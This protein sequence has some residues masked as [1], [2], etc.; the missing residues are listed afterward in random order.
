M[1]A[2]RHAQIKE[3]FIRICELPEQY[4]SAALDRVC[5]DDL[6][7]RREVE[8]LLSFHG[9]SA[10][11]SANTM[12][13]DPLT[14]H[15]KKDPER[16][17]PYR[18]LRKLGEG[19]MGVVYE[20]RQDQPVRRKLALKL[21]KWGMDTEEVLARFESERQALAIMNHPNVA[22]VFEAGSTEKG[23]PYFTMEYVEGESLTAYCD[24]H[25]LN[26]H[27]RLE[28]FMQVCDGV[29]HAH[30]NGII[31][32]DIK[33]SNVLVR[34][35]EDKPVPTIIDFGVAKATQQRLTERTLYT[36]RGMLIGTPEYMSPEQA[37]LSGPDVDTRTDVYSLGVVLY[38]ILVGALPFDSKTLR[39]AGFDEIRRKIREEEPSKPSTRVSTLGDASSETARR[40]RT[41]PANLRRELSGDMDWIT[42]K[43]LEKDRTRRYTS[44]AE[45]TA[46]IARHLRHEPVLASPSST[47]ERVSK[48]VRRHWIGVAAWSSVMLALAIGLAL[49]TSG[50][51]RAKRAE[52][53]ARQEAATATKVSEL[54]M[55]LFD[56]L[57][58]GVPGHVVTLEQILERGTQR[59]ETELA[60]E[61]V[62]Q[63]RLL[64]YLA[65]AQG[66]V[67]NPGRG[68][69]LVERSVQLL[70]ENLP[71][72]HPHLGASV[73]LLGDVVAA[74]GD[75]DQAQRLHEEALG[76]WK[77]SLGPD[78]TSVSLGRAYKSL[79]L[80]QFQ[81]GNL[82][83]SRSYMDKAEWVL[84]RFTGTYRIH[85]AYTLYWQGLLDS[86]YEG[87]HK[88]ALAR[89]EQALEI[90]ETEFGPEHN[91][92]GNPLFLLGQIHYRLGNIETARSYYDRVLSIRER[93]FGEDSHAVAKV[94]T[95]LGELLVATG[96]ME[97]ARQQLERAFGILEGNA[98][99]AN[100]DTAWCVRCL[101]TVYRQSGEVDRARQLLQ[102]SLEALE[103]SMGSDHPGLTRTLHHL[104]QLELQAGNLEPAR[105]WYRQTLEIQSKTWE[106]GHYVN[107]WALY[108]LACIAVREGKNEQA[109]SLLRQAL[110]NGYDRETILEDT[111]LANLRGDL[112]F[113]KIVNEVE[114]RLLRKQ[115]TH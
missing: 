25:C 112:E 92:A 16:I 103:S 18:V 9:K 46:D 48:F 86:E 87:D 107:T 111:D 45:L 43:A 62:L 54:L 100:A 14:L 74:T 83:E 88:A 105:R 80:I 82:A 49:A 65:G 67:G 38:E 55:H 97:P 81:R 6:D 58:S 7:L 29:Q 36:E 30:Q 115:A 47:F 104:G 3:L 41:D 1:N 2:D 5:G 109:L 98:G 39:E 72:D 64:G 8:S 110:D 57:N 94:M 50:L 89:L 22:K 51:V 23:R 19:G 106:P 75:L 52:Q 76:I 60:E 102:R 70:R 78:G 79:G 90:L 33:S 91:Q 10:A 108:Q 32:R 113:E 68:R 73:A 40:R 101:A 114:Q 99:M 69:E 4:R 85:L 53:T 27:E 12:A 15:S 93:E 24:R 26:T 11:T 61:P 20:V 71:P 56:D 77:R 35:H 37:E 44:P 31:H 17:G 59:I 66:S 21:V 42:M 95:G 63:A 13:S 96:D 34:I 84:G 28:L